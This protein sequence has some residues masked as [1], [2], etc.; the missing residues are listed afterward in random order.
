VSP[1]RQG[2]ERQVAEVEHI[3]GSHQVAE[4]CRDE[5]QEGPTR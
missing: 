5:E 4:E 2:L 3:V 1:E